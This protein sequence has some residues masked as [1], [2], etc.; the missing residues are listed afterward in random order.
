MYMMQPS[1][2]YAPHHPSP[3]MVPPQQF[4]GQGMTVQHYMGQQGSEGPHQYGMS[5]GVQVVHSAQHSEHYMQ[6]QQQQQQQ[7]Y[8]AGSQPYGFAPHGSHM[9]PMRQGAGRRGHHACQWCSSTLAG[10]IIS[11]AP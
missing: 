9:M 7:H 5:Q 1:Q 3:G 8:M 6:G 11:H 4:M 10:L 2:M